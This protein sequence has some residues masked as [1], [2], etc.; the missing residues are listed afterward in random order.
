MDGQTVF[1]DLKIRAGWGVMG[2]SNN[3]DP[4]NQFSLFATSLGA[5][6]YDINGTNTSAAQGFF[7]SRIGNPFAKWERAIT[8]NVGIDALLFDGKL[9][10]GVELWRKDTEDLLFVQPVTVMTGQFASAPSVNVGKMRNNGLDFTIINKGRINS[11]FSYE[12]SFTG[13][14]LN[15]EIVELADGIEDLPNRSA[16]Y[17]GIT[18][19]LNQVCLLYTS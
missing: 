14:F 9:D 13:G 19:V 4:N 18:P 12:V 6:S 3:V 8:S 1:D 11:D 16:S 10:V 7:R 5:S 15:N 17:R 2:N